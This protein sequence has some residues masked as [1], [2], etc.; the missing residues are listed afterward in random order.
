MLAFQQCMAGRSM[1]S[2]WLRAPPMQTFVFGLPLTLSCCCCTLPTLTPPQVSLPMSLLLAG[3]SGPGSTIVGALARAGDI[4]RSHNDGGLIV[5]HDLQA[6]AVFVD[7]SAGCGSRKD[8]RLAHTP[9]WRL[10]W[11]QA[12][13]HLKRS[14]DV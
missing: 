6:G 10:P 3:G 8:Y 14:E 13:E 2:R 5:E 1:M 4:H 12:R 7:N 11:L 9:R